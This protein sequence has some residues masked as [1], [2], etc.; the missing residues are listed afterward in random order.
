MTLAET[1]LGE[2][3]RSETLRR[4]V[5]RFEALGLEW[6]IY[7]GCAARLYGTSRLTEDIDVVVRAGGESLE[8]LLP[9]WVRIH[10]GAVA[11]GDVEVSSSP[12]FFGAHTGRARWTWDDD[13]S[14]RL[15]V[16]GIGVTLVRVMGVE[17]FLVIKALQQRGPE[18]GKHDL[19]DIRAVL[20]AAQGRLDLAYV[21]ARA[22]RCRASARVCRALAARGESG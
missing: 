5:G 3:A 15:L 14:E 17:D 21:L 11:L 8:Q 9:D 18:V 7:G 20:A 4:A 2:L 10:P 16:F 1:F 6:C 13:V 19:E 22:N 12:L